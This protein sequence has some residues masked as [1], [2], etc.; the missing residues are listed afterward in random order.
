MENLPPTNSLVPQSQESL[1][2]IQQ[3]MNL[4]QKLTGKYQAEIKRGQPTA[5]V[6][7]IDQSGSMK[8]GNFLYKGVPH[9]KAAAVTRILNN[10]LDELVNK[11]TKDY[12][13]G[14]Y[15][16]IAIIG[17]GQDGKKA[18][19]IW[20]GNLQGKTWVTPPELKEN[21]QKTAYKELRKTRMGETEVEIYEHSWFS[22]VAANQTPM[23]DALCQAEQ[24]LKTWVA[25][26]PN[27]YPPTVINITDG[28]ATDA[29]NDKLVQKANDLK[30]IGTQDGNTLLF[31]VFVESSTQSEAVLFPH[32][33]SQLP[34]DTHAQLLYEM[35]SL[36]PK[37]YHQ[38]IMAVLQTAHN[39]PFRAMVHNADARRLVQVMNVGTRTNQKI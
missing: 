17:Y 10:T 14:E 9:T 33:L 24:L 6:F 36:M 28:E 5:F 27:S 31:N 1:Q 39:Q 8:G 3:M 4:V 25:Q 22:A 16:D 11:C 20:E 32:D 37:N 30:N 38:D 12:G 21:A 19:L 18:N 29:D 7:L 13:I 34:N 23:Y 26:H 35:A 2:R 15:F